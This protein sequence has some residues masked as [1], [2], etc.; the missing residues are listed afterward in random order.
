MRVRYVTA[1]LLTPLRFLSVNKCRNTKQ[2]KMQILPGVDF[3]S[4]LI[5]HEAEYGA[6]HDSYR[7]FGVSTDIRDRST[8][9][10]LDALES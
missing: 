7:W 10:C 4:L 5:S 1:G 6:V 9:P 8:G 3:S 2:K